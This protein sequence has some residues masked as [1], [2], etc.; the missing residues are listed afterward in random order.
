MADKTSGKDGSKDSEK[1]KH[2]PLG[3]PSPLF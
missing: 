1:K 3:L 2:I